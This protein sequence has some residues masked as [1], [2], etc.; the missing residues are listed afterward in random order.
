MVPRLPNGKQV[1]RYNGM[2]FGT[3]GIRVV[4][5]PT[6]SNTLK[7]L[8][9]LSTYQRFNCS[10]NNWRVLMIN[11]YEHRI[12]LMKIASTDISTQ[13]Q[14]STN[15]HGSCNMSNYRE[16]IE[17]HIIFSPVYMSHWLDT[18]NLSDKQ[19]LGRSS[20]TGQVQIENFTHL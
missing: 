14:S 1:H 11:S 4:I 19:G 2:V 7:A 12:C 10:R 16:S 20:H 3:S 15:D 18:S 8:E 5:I 9:P 17:N 6:T 13:L